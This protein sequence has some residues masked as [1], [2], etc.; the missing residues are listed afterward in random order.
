M[1]LEMDPAYVKWESRAPLRLSVVFVVLIA[2]CIVAAAANARLSTHV[3]QALAFVISSNL[4]Y[5]MH[6]TRREGTKPH[7]VIYTSKDD[8]VLNVHRRDAVVAITLSEIRKV[9]FQ[10][11]KSRLV[12]IRIKTKLDQSVRIAKYQNMSALADLLKSTTKAEN[13]K[14]A[15]WLSL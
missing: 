12:S 10:Y 6:R 8:R 1:R 11:R 2:G 4:F 5:R 14:I 13:L 9:T 15:A 3:M 7:A